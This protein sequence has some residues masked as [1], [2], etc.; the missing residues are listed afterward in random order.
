[1][2]QIKYSVIMPTL[3]RD[4]EHRQVFAET[5]A[6][7]VENSNNYELIIIDDGSP[8]NLTEYANPDV[9]IVHK[10]NKGIAPSWND[11]LRMA[12]G[13]YVCIINDDITVQPGWLDTMESV[14]PLFS[15]NYKTPVV[16]APGVVGKDDGKRDYEANHSWFPG[17]CFMMHQSTI[18]T[19]LSGFSPVGYFDEQFTPFNYEDTDFWVRLLKAGGKLVRMYNTMITHREGDVLHKLEYGE[20][21]RKNKRKFIEKWGFDPIDYFYH[22]GVQPW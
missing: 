9:W 3:T 4:E 2:S 1:M 12:R 14:F 8:L 10:E 7:V 18:Q 17:F 19:S 16:V 11:G 13:K 15:N 22:G 20:V 21:S 6:S 5:V